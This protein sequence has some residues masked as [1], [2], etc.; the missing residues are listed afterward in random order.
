[1][2]DF[3]YK[4]YRDLDGNSLNPVCVDANTC[5][6]NKEIDRENEMSDQQREK[7]Q[8]LSRI[9]KLEEDVR[10]HAK[11]L[12][13]IK[14]V[15]Q[16]QSNGQAKLSFG[17]NGTTEIKGTT[18]LHGKARSFELFLLFQLSLLFQNLALPIIWEPLLKLFSF[19]FLL[20]PFEWQICTE[21][22]FMSNILPTHGVAARLGKALAVE[23]RM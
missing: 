1:M 5:G 12:E 19:Y 15:M 3:Q 13:L 8:L 11:E 6:L 7:D 2:F 18:R 16:D 22:V 23:T 21:L 4:P 14:Q 10:A 20:F 9:S 17:T